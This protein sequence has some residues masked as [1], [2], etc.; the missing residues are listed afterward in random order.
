MA[1]TNTQM[2]LAPFDLGE[3]TQ[4]WL[5]RSQFPND[6]DLQGRVD[7][8]RLYSGALGIAEIASLV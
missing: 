4:S 6:P 7:D 2:T 3:T 8:F 1:G 5:G